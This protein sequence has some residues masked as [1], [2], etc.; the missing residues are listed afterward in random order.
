[1]DI[2]SLGPEL[3]ALVDELME[4]GRFASRGDVLRE[5]VRLVGER[6]RLLAKLDDRLSNGLADVAAGRTEDA[7][8]VFD[9]LIAKCEAQAATAAN[10][11]KPAA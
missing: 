4:S 8:I 10:S 9:R 7:E 1:M 2:H 6:E 11:V 5:G 3:E